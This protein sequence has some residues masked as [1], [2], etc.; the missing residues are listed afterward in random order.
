MRTE[1]TQ[2]V[3]GK[4]YSTKTAQVVASDEYWDGHNH[5]RHGHNSHLYKSP[6]GAFFVVHSTQWQGELDSLQLLSVEEA[7][8]MYEKLPEHEMTYSEAFGVEPEEG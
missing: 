3:D 4:R 7:K 8:E 1:L 6:K 5:E 2:I